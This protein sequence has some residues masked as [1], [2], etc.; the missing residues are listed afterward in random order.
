MGRVGSGSTI[1]LGA[2]V[3]HDDTIDD[4][5]VVIVLMEQEVSILDTPYQHLKLILHHMA[6]NARTEA[7]HMTRTT[8]R[9]LDEIDEEAIKAC[10]KERTEQA[11]QALTIFERGAASQTTGLSQLGL[12][13][14]AH[15]DYCGCQQST[16]EHIIWYCPKFN[17]VRDNA[18]PDLVVVHNRKVDDEDQ[19]RKSH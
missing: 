12:N 2:I 17:E 11:R 8:N 16:L 13:D 1:P 10:D 15:C 18:A 9:V 19:A 14:N 6:A 3:R 5:F 7:A 4:D